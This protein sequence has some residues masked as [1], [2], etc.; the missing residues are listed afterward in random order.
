MYWNTLSDSIQATKFRLIE[1]W[2]VLKCVNVLAVSFGLTWLI[3]TWD[4]LKY[5]AEDGKP[6]VLVD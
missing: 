5:E 1:T 3:E 6:F 2:D 4:V